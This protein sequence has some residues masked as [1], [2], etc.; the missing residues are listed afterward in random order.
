MAGAA[1]STVSF[2]LNG[3]DKEMRISPILAERIRTI[4]SDAHY[5]PNR[6]AVSLRTGRSNIIGLIVDNI[7]GSFF[8]SLAQYIESDLE[9]YGY[10]V[11][12]CS[13]GNDKKKSKDLIR[14]LNL[15]QVDGFL[16][17]PS[18][19]V[20]KELEALLKQQKPLVL[21]DSFFPGMQA[22]HVLVNN[23]DGVCKGM[24]HLIDKGYRNI[25]I[26]LND[27]GLVQM[28]ERKR[29]YN[30]TL[31]GA[32]MPIQKRLL[33]QTSYN[34]SKEDITAAII[35]FIQT[36]KPDAIFFS[37][38]YLGICGLSAIRQIGLHMPGD[39]AVVCFD[40]HELFSL[41]QPGITAV[42]QPIKEIAATAVEILLSQ[43]DASN[44]NQKLR[45]VQINATL[46]KRF[47]A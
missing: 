15:Y 14:M 38:N 23:Y 19:G 24:T 4:A 12:Y 1:T 10:K 7:S 43:M 33:L 11:I 8:A 31:R 36:Q 9:Q 17:T 42:Q 29:A 40:D 34:A 2:V 44:K 20:E 32:G 5:E 39:V 18:E 6:V 41:H 28:K 16:I 22:S 13:T 27:V 21:I 30:E 45:Q 47:S 26:V 3:K 25:A 35:D 37:A 46:L